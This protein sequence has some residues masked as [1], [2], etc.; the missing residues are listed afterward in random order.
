MS[1]AR[2]LAVVTWLGASLFGMRGAAADSLRQLSEVG[3]GLA[4]HE[5]HDASWVLKRRPDLV[6]AF[7]SV[8]GAPVDERRL[9]EQPLFDAQ[10]EL[11]SAPGFARDYRLAWVPAAGGVVAIHR[12][13][14]SP[15]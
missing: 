12:R 4:G 9:L 10:R 15:R 3:G 8:W 5:K 6:L 2:T 11:I 1:A 13:V 14:A 7:P